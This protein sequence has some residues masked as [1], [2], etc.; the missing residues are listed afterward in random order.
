MVEAAGVDERVMRLRRFAIY[1]LFGDLQKDFLLEVTLDC[2]R[3]FIHDGGV[4]KES[5]KASTTYRCVQV[6]SQLIG[7]SDGLVLSDVVRNP[8]NWGWPRV[9]RVSETVRAASLGLIGTILGL[10]HTTVHLEMEDGSLILEKTADCGTWLRYPGLTERSKRVGE[11]V[12]FDP[13][14]RFDEVFN[15]IRTHA[16]FKGPMKINYTCQ[17][18]TRDCFRSLSDTQRE[19]HNQSVFDMVEQYFPTKPSDPHRQQELLRLF[20]STGLSQRVHELFS[21]W[22]KQFQLEPIDYV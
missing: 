17:H 1:P 5:G 12:S 22:R 6:S 14:K 4:L 18:F 11:A 20:K 10:K 2:G 8:I 15:L 19:L 21:P 3:I 7:T 13:P 16:D 9:K